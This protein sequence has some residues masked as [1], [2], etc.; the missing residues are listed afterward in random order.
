VSPYT[1][2]EAGQHASSGTKADGM[3]VLATALQLEESR[4]E[5]ARLRDVVETLS[6][7]PCTDGP[8]CDGLCLPCA[9][10]AA[11]EPQ[12]DDEE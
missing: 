11:L 3:R 6:E 2:A 7:S 12:E 4:A 10:R 9:A 1:S 8:G 5:A